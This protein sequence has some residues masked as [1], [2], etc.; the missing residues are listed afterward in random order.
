M[1]D[2]A[3]I[4][5][6]SVFTGHVGSRFRIEIGPDEYVDAT[7]I[8]AEVVDSGSGHAD[9]AARVPFSLLFELPENV[10]LTQQTY[11]VSQEQLGEWPLFLVPVAANR[12]ESTFN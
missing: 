3:K 4:G 6:V 8:E 5:D 9:A 1:I 11:N 2:L 12:V 7:L 10:E